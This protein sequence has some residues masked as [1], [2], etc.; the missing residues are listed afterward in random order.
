MFDMCVRK[1]YTAILLFE[2]IF[3]WDEKSQKKYIIFFAPQTNFSTSSYLMLMERVYGAH[4]EEGCLWQYSSSSLK[5]S[6]AVPFYIIS[7]ISTIL[8]LR[9][10][11]QNEEHM[12]VCALNTNIHKW[13]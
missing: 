5:L 9:S 8:N 6:S 11:N 1:S 2:Y 4:G 13:N 10:L 12:N 7:A 3:M